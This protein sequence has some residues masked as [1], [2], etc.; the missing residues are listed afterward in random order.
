M[1][2]TPLAARSRTRSSYSKRLSRPMSPVST[3]RIS[4]GRLRFSIR[5]M[6]TVLSTLPA[7]ADAQSNG[8]SLKD[9][10]VSDE[11]PRRNGEHVRRALGVVDGAL[12]AA[13]R[14]AD[15]Q[16]R[17]GRDADSAGSARAAAI[18]TWLDIAALAPALATSPAT[19]K[20]DVDS[21]RSNLREAVRRYTEIEWGHNMFGYALVYVPFLW[22]YTEP[23]WVRTTARSRLRP[24][25]R[26]STWQTLYGEAASAQRD[27]EVNTNGV[28]PSSSNQLS[29]ISMQIADLC[30]A[31]DI[32]DPVQCG[33]NGT[34]K[35]VEA[36]PRHP[37]C[38]HAN[39]PDREPAREL[40]DGDPD[41]GGSCF[42]HR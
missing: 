39:G 31:N 19:W 42:G 15:L 24:T 26:R 22:K 21:V 13:T 28:K 7:A 37:V 10:P 38:G 27:F 9:S 2:G 41:R 3:A 20:S 35:L 23:S 25:W 12:F 17:I 4:R 6:P 29:A 30:G 32:D 5:S 33:K 18:R 14:R 8:S 11:T 40:G 36:R 34:G 1:P 16:R